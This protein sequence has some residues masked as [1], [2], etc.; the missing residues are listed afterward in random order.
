MPSRGAKSQGLKILPLT[1][2]SP[3][4]KMRNS[5]KPVIPIDREGRGYRLF[6]LKIVEGKVKIPHPF[7]YAQGRL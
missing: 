3:R 7:D 1:Y 6:G 2:C 4:I 5:F